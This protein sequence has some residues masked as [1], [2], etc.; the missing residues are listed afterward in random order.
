V[1]PL[2]IEYWFQSCF[3]L[4]HSFSSALLY[5]TKQAIKVKHTLFNSCLLKRLFIW[6]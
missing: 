1:F 3:S 4:G 2:T 6:F 5:N